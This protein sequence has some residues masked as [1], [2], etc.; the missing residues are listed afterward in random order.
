MSDI[1]PLLVR[2]VIG[3][4]GGALGKKSAAAAA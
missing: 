4:A 3:R 1:E 2:A